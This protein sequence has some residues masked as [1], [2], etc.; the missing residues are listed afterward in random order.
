[1]DGNKYKTKIPHSQKL[2]ARV[3]K[4][5]L[6]EKLHQNVIHKT[7]ASYTFFLANKTRGQAPY[8]DEEFNSNSPSYKENKNILLIQGINELEKNCRLV[9]L[10]LGMMMQKPQIVRVLCE[11]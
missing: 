11:D 7:L 5:I 6:L 4:D 3:P 9:V 10:I 8:L 2:N 1:M